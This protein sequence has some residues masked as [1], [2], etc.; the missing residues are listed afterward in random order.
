MTKALKAKAKEL[1]S[2][3][4]RTSKVKNDIHGG[5]CVGIGQGTAVKT[6][7]TYSV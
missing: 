5:T 2:V 3:M 7:I 6:T 4:S 1:V